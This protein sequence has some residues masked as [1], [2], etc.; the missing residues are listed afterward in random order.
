ML[1]ATSPIQDTQ[2][3]TIE[4]TTHRWSHWLLICFICLF[5][6]LPLTHQ[7][8]RVA[9]PL[10]KQISIDTLQLDL[11]RR[12]SSDIVVDL[13]Q[14]SQKQKNNTLMSHSHPDLQQRHTNPNQRHSVKEISKDPCECK[15]PV[16]ESEVGS[17]KEAEDLGEHTDPVHAS[18]VGLRRVY[19]ETSQTCIEISAAC[20]EQ[21]Q[22]CTKT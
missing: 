21:N 15:D 10:V 11:I 13:V 14:K 9:H 2:L 7:T 20:T 5:S 12:E 6:S 22:A 18:A 3:S 4:R 8:H 17:I 19:T 1:K 16:H